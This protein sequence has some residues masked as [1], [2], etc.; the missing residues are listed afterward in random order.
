M[1]ACV[2]LSYF[3]SKKPLPPSP[4]IFVRDLH[5]LSR[6]PI[7]LNYRK[8]YLIFEFAWHGSR[9]FMGINTN[10]T[11]IKI[12][13]LCSS[14]LNSPNYQYYIYFHKVNP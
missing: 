1:L 9:R 7:Q 2:P 11:K 3:I 13:V 12:L 5:M 8:G 14:N 4:Q 6:T 10:S